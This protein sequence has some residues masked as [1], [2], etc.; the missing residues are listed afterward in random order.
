M[1]LWASAESHK[2]ETRH[3]MGQWCGEQN[4]R[5]TFGFVQKRPALVEV[6]TTFCPRQ[7]FPS[8][9][10]KGREQGFGPVLRSTVLV[11]RDDS[12]RASTQQGTEEP[13][14]LHSNISSCT[15][16][17]FFGRFLLQRSIGTAQRPASDKRI[18]P[19]PLWD[20]LPSRT[21][22]KVRG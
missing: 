16:K 20:Y 17:H 7:A 13:N 19:F 2:R 4:G 21:V 14:I 15:S 9:C 5:R 12:Y 18:T 22:S 3:N 11:L 10:A 1:G 6:D 8:L